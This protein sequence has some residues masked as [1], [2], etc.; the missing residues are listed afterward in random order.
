[1]VRNAVITPGKL[2]NLSEILGMESK[3]KM[4]IFAYY[5][6]EVF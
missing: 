6:T 5:F 3:S 4:R 1:M 2:Q